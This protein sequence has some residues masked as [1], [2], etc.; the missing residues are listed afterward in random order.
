MPT[1]EQLAPSA[2][3]T[4]IDFWS[5]RYVVESAERLTVRNDVAEAPTRERDAGVMVS[6]QHGGGLGYA[7][8][9]DVSERGL[10]QAF[11][12]AQGLAAASAA[13]SVFDLS[14]IH[15]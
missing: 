15:I 5:V 11:A 4:G 1:I 2:A 12:Q 7:A 13:H 9:S 10:R 8:T 6:V 3:P 14:L